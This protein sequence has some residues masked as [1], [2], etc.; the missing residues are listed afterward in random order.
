[1]YEE[2]SICVV[3]SHHMKEA[4]NFYLWNWNV[5]NGTRG[6]QATTYK[7]DPA[8]PIL[9]GPLAKNSFY[10]FKWLQKKNLNNNISEPDTLICPGMAAFL[11]QW[12]N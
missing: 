5:V 2:D 7:P 6:W 1:M 3:Q 8:T 9:Y 11:L 12:Q 10:I 4:I